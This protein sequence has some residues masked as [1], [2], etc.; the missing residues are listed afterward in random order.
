MPTDNRTYS[1]VTPVC[2]CSA[3]VSC[4]CVVVAGWNTR[5]TTLPRFFA[6]EKNRTA[7]AK[8]LACSRSLQIGVKPQLGAFRFLAFRAQKPARSMRASTPQGLPCRVM[9]TPL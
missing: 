9:I 5:D 6:N 4:E 3:G 1:G 8:A 2:A 7:F